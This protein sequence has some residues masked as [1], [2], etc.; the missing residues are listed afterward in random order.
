MMEILQQLTAIPGVVGSLACDPRGE[1]LALEFPSVFEES[2]LKRVA[3]LL[4][5]DAG[6]LPSIVRPDGTLELRYTGGRAI[7][8]RFPTGTLLLVCTSAINPQLLALSLTQCW[9]R[10]ERFGVRPAAVPPP[11]SPVA[12]GPDLEAVRERLLQALLR[13]IGPIGDMVFAQG[14]D[15]W[16]ASG[17]PSPARLENLVAALAREIDEGEAR[18]R[19]QAEAT[20]IITS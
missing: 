3:A 5:D 17:P 1:I 16:I 4:A 7:V 6:A 8:R 14:W 18:A 13:R 10:L 19:F 15:A 11:P 2:T 12:W 9:R 20:A